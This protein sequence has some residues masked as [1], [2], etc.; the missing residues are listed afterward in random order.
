MKAIVLTNKGIEDISKK[1][2]KELIN[3]DAQIHEGFLTFEAE[4]KDLFVLCYKA[5]SLTKVIMVADDL[6]EYVKNKTFAVRSHEKELEIKIA[7]KIQGKV[8]LK[9]PDVT[10]YAVNEKYY[11]IDLT[12]EDLSRRDYRIFLGPES[13]KGTIAYALVRLS[14]YDS[15]KTLL[16]PFCRDGIIPIE[17]ALYA[18]KRS[19]NYFKKDKF[20]FLKIFPDINL[21]KLDKIAEAKISVNASD[22]QMIH[23]NAAKK[24]AKI[25]GVNKQ[26][27]FSRVMLKDI[28]LKFNDVDCLATMPVQGKQEEFFKQA[29]LVMKKNGKIVL[30]MRKD[31]EKY[32]E[33]G[34]KFKLSE[35]RKVMQ[36]KEEWTILV[37]TCVS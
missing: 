13:L 21:E 6:N 16:D 9:N 30:I 8:D 34:N 4:Q 37:F 32:K 3:A 31:S 33:A 2:I 11:G 36:G 12:G 7:E 19:P 1:E 29:E 10:I 24:N 28:D 26:I 22:A 25:A 14:G 23:V 5:Q 15:S 27:S 18:T 35:E 20:A 17:A